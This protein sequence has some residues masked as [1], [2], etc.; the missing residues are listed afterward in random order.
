M[1][2]LNKNTKMV[3]QSIDIEVAKSVPI[4]NNRRVIIR[5][6]PSMTMSFVSTDHKTTIVVTTPYDSEVEENLLS[7]QD[8][9]L[10]L[11]VIADIFKP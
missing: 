2:K 6:L 8:K 5:T 1:V 4:S 10:S 3:L 9:H 7:V 11:D